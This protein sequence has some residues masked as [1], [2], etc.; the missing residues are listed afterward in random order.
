WVLPSSL[1]ASSLWPARHRTAARLTASCSGTSGSKRLG[2]PTAPGRNRQARTRA[3]LAASGGGDG[4]G[5]GRVTSM[6][7]SPQPDGAAALIWPALTAALSGPNRP[8]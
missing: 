2:L 4:A 7:S 8:S 6:L 1:A 5:G 3:A